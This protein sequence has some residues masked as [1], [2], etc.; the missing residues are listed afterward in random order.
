M[1]VVS[2]KVS[3]DLDRLMEEYAK[4]LGVTKSELIR[5]AII[6]YIDSR[7]RKPYISRRVRVY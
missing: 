1:K 4:A 2:F 3:E 7:R 6:E 5:R